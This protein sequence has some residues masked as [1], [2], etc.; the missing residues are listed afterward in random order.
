MDFADNWN[1]SGNYKEKVSERTLQMNET[2]T[3]EQPYV[4]GLDIGTRN[5]VGT[6]GYKEGTE[7]VVVAQ[8]IM[9][10][11]TRAMIDGQ[12]HDIGRVGSVIRTVKEELEK[13]I[14]CPLTEVCIA[15]AGRVLKTVTT[16]VEYEYPEETVVTKEDIHTLD[17]LGIEKAQSILK[18]KN[19][20]RY[21]FYCVGYSV[22]KYY[23]NEEVYS[24][25][26]GHKAEVI[27]EDIIVTFL[28]EDVVDGLYS[29]VAQAGLD[30]ANMTLEPIAAIDV[31]IP[32][33]FRMLNI[34]LVDVGAGTSD[35][36]V[37]K[38][39]SIIA[40]GMIPLAGDELTELIV[41][42]YLVDFQTAERIKLASTTGEMITYKDIMMIEHSIPA[43]EVWELVEPVADKMTTAVAEKIKELNGGQSVS[44]TFVVGG[45]GKIHGFTEMLADKLGLPQ[46]RVAL[47]GEE[48][49]QEVTF[50]QPDI[51]KDP[52]IVTPIGI[53][54]NYY[55]QK[56]SFIMVHLNGE[57]IK[58]YDN[59]KLLIMDAA[60]QAGVAN[61]DLF[62]KRG[63]EVNYTVNGVA[64]VERGLPGESAVITMN[65]KPA[66]INTKLEPNSDIEIC[67]STVG[68]DAMITIEQLEEYHTSTIT[69][70]VNGKKIACPR[71][72]EVNGELEPASYQI[73]EGDEIE[74]RA[75]YTVEQI[76]EFMDVEIDTEKEI[77]V[78]NRVVDLNYLVYENFNIEWTILSFRTHES[79]TT[80][81]KT[82][83]IMEEAADTT[84]VS[85]ENVS[86]SEAAG[87]TEDSTPVDDASETAD[88]KTQTAEE[89]LA[90]NETSDDAKEKETH[91]VEVIINGTPVKLT[92]RESYM[93]V[94]LFEFYEFDLS[95]SAGRAIITKLNGQNAQYTAELKDG[96]VI[97]LAWKEK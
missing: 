44:A 39:G 79:D 10:H 3:F 60:L 35:I 34:A 20:T 90:D 37:T 64:K 25:I 22:V 76:A 15:A 63:K 94:D 47:R 4:F 84:E 38:D 96:D 53:C 95:A 54:L 68:A 8:Y 71:F 74:T 86:D 14:E 97:E 30:V 78:N 1:G 80:E 62:P 67:P 92:G 5:V 81:E 31:A 23:L 75:Y 50:E 55:D 45:G 93:F 41:Q 12:I 87:E 83:E 32:E 40:Y 61:E 27:S 21:K 6:V 88:E 9:Q 73:K 82:A 18:E 7:F 29:A 49:L 69:F 24:N 46:E 26:E 85:E 56:N 72:V 17:L 16:N 11:E 58:M 91:S 36:S 65:G 48:V 89:S 28:P 57:R 13:Q 43:K 70:I 19:D 77:I 52:L 59:N 33:T 2:Q 42:H 51:E 66:S